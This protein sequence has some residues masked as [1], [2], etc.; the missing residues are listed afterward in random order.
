MTLLLPEQRLLYL[1]ALLLILGAVANPRALR[2]FFSFHFWAVILAALL[3]GVLWLGEYDAMIL[4]IGWSSEG[5]VQGTFVALRAVALLL[6]FNV[7][8]G[9]MS[10]SRWARVFASLGLPG[11]GFALG[12]AF[13]LFPTLRELGEAAYHS[14][15]LRGGFRKPILAMRLFLLTTTANALRYGDEV[16]KAASSRAF[17]PISL[18]RRV[19]PIQP[20]DLALFGVLGLGTIGLLWV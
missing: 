16:V 18:P 15:R 13:N 11:L 9:V 1:V 19:V 3:I 17:D 8:A 7:A 5:L 12:V 4:G 10:V 14:I 6:A 2:L 20:Q